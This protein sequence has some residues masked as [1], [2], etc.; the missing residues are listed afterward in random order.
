MPVAA[1][2]A[3]HLVI[4]GDRQALPAHL[5]LAGAKKP[6]GSGDPDLFVT[7]NYGSLNIAP[8]P[9]QYDTVI[10]TIE[11]GMGM[12]AVDSADLVLDRVTRIKSTFNLSMSDLASV[13][14]VERP[15]I[16]AW[17][18]EDQ[19]PRD[20]NQRRIEV[21]AALASD[22]QRHFGVTLPRGAA[23]IPVGGATLIELL[24]EETVDRSKV[25]EHVMHLVGEA[26]PK[27]GVFGALA[28]RESQAVER[29]R[30]AQDRIDALTGKPT[31]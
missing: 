31:S 17:L 30:D 5:G 19:I 1:P 13:L 12:N 20:Y 2:P 27:R 16:Y 3:H 23:K 8:Y 22:L 9:F 24:S 26:T 14:Q 4:S 18:R 6:P 25:Q 28:A 29:P 15:T 11:P 7:A 10:V 21:L